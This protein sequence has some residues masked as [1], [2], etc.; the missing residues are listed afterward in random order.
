MHTS[1]FSSSSSFSFSTSSYI[2]EPLLHLNHQ[3]TRPRR[4]HFEKKSLP[5]LWEGLLP[6]LTSRGVL[7]V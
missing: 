2:S 6:S 7:G 5:V 1:L 3:G 4:R